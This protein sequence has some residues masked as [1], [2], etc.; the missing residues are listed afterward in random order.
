MSI[1]YGSS[2]GPTEGIN[3]STFEVVLFDES[4]QHPWQASGPPPDRSETAGVVG[5]ATVWL[6]DVS[7]ADF[8][9]TMDST[10]IADAI[11]WKE[12][13][14]RGGISVQLA[15]DEFNSPVVALNIDPNLIGEV[16]SGTHYFVQQH[17]EAIKDGIALAPWAWKISDMVKDRRQ[18]ALRGA[19]PMR[20]AELEDL[21]RGAVRIQRKLGRDDS[22]VLGGIMYAKHPSAKWAAI[23]RLDHAEMRR[24]Y[25]VEIMVKS[26]GN[27]EAGSVS[28]RSLDGWPG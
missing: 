10:N 11:W 7:Q 16:V 21:A 18:N 26:N 19:L 25:A 2:W 28:W 9:D 13:H 1:S 27:L 5:V 3:G 14:L 4:L 15:Y 12:P 8:I 23:V 24:S 20:E 22:L 17:G 6:P